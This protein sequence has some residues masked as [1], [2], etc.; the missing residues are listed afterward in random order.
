MSSPPPAP[1]APP[2]APA[3]DLWRVVALLAIAA[4]VHG[5][6]VAHTS[7]TA[8]DSIGLAR[9]AFA[10]DDSKRNWVDVLREEAHPPGYP[11]A[12]VAANKLVGAGASHPDTDILLSAQIASSVAGVLIVLPVYWLGRRLFDRSVGFWAA[13]LLQFLPVFARDTADGLTDGPFLLCALSAIACGVWALDRPR[14]WPGLLACGV[15]SGLAYLVRPEGAI[16][17][18]ATAVALL[19]QTKRLG[20][21]RVAVGLL[22]V[23]IGFG[24][25]GGPYMATIRGITNKPALT[26]PGAEPDPVAARGPLFAESIPPDQR[27]WGLVFVTG[28][29]WLKAGHYGVAVAAIIGLV[30]NAGRVRRE[31]KFWLPVLYAGGQ[32]AVVTAVGLN[33]WYVSERHLLPVAA[34]GVL[35]AAGGLPAWFRL[36]SKLPGVGRAFVWKWWPVVAC[37]T[38]VVAG[39]V[40]IL[41]T[42]LHEDRL[43]HKL[44]GAELAKAIDALSDEQRAGVVVMDHYQWCQFFSGR[45]TRAIPPDPPE[46]DQ[47]V[48]FVVLELKNGEVEKPDF[49]SPRHMQAVKVYQE[50]PAGA[51]PTPVYHWPAGPPEKAKVLLA[52]ITLPAR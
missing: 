19:L 16:V 42:H 38:F 24:A 26:K 39:A 6:V 10:L 30:L 44:A 11:L 28:K 41:N 15:L 45:A 50:P 33:K 23:A 52:R 35:F 3:A 5:W 1:D 20:F 31:P 18:L 48:V 37:V 36:W 7:I 47:R 34:V 9:Y 27:P 17:P 4:A 22:V 8:R 51:T 29:E 49:D 21:G 32:V 13:L 14:V 2:R 46:A 43:G 25:V 40:P 12:V